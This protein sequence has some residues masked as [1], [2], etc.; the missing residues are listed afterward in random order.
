MIRVFEPRLS[1][2][3][4]I[5]MVSNLRK[6]EISGTSNTINKFEENLADYFD[7]KYAIAVSNG[8]VALELAVKQLD[9]KK[10]DEVIVPSFTI[11]SCLS[12]VV[13]SEATP[14]F[15]DVDLDSWNM[16]LEN[17]KKVKTERT[18]AVIMVHTYGLP[19]P[20]KEIEKYCNENE[21]ILIEDAAE[22][23]GQTEYGRK[24]GS[25]GKISTLSFYANKHVTTGE[26]GAVL[27][28]SD[29]DYK[30]LKKMINLDFGTPNR[31]N[32]DNF[33]WNYRLS[34]LQA[35]LG[36][37]NLRNID[38]TI[39]LKQ[40]QGNYYST[41]FSSLQDHIQIPKK[42]YNLSKNHYWVYGIVLKK[43]N[44]R[45]ELIAYLFD[46]GIETREFFW[47][48]HLQ[49]ALLKGTDSKVTLKNSEYLGSR[50]L[51]IP[52]GKHIK[53]KDQDYI[54]NKIKNFLT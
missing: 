34:G 35:S 16:T 37:S 15:C 51:Y 22:A 24:C 45:N 28:D 26:G 3:D 31:F 18:K 6:N 19:S 10:G 25:F 44:L 53:R 32:H 11:I 42:E 8:T 33:Y 2:K 13:R 5:A 1:I 29:S 36:I 48:L 41:K 43:Q 30:K 7:R 12:A 4:Q 39:A 50:G 40:T 21:I 54:F 47:P 27:T 14:V 52:I 38:K 49:N 17:I 9:L 20:A 46:S 23:H